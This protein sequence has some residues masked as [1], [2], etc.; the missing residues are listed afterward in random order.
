MNERDE[1]ILKHH[2]GLKLSPY[3]DTKGKL[4]IGW[5]HNLDAKPISKRAAQVILEDDVADAEAA[6]DKHLPWWR[7]L[8]PARQF[9]LMNMMFNMGP[10]APGKGGLLSFVNTLKAIKEGRWL[11]A[12]NGMY[13]SKWYS[14]VKPRRAV[15]LI[16]MMETG[17]Y[18]KED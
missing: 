17:Q 3:R 1:A 8:A 12:A 6:L 2:E 10:G 7:D 4:T 11:D 15:P 16:R 9:V 14:D 18:P 5:G 13:L